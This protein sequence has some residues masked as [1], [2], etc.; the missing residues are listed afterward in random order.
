MNFG[1]WLD[2]CFCLTVVFV[3]P[4]DANIQPRITGTRMSEV[5]D[6]ARFFLVWGVHIRIDRWQILDGCVLAGYHSGKRGEG[7]RRD[8]GSWGQLAEKMFR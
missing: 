3:S 8:P 1:L 7:R 5:L 2:Y 6:F 4:E